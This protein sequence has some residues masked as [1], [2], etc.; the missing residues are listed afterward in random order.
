VVRKVDRIG[1]EIIALRLGD[2]GSSAATERIRRALRSVDQRIV[3][4]A[5]QLAGQTGD[6]KFASDLVDT[7]ER[8]LAGGQG[9]DPL[10]RAK[11]AVLATLTELG[12]DDFDVY[13]RALKVRQFDPS[14]GVPPPGEETAGAVRSISALKLPMTGLNTEDLVRSLGPMLFDSSPHVRQNV[15][16]ALGACGS[17]EAF[18]LIEVKLTA[19]DDE[20]GVLGECFSELLNADIGR[21]LE[22]VADYLNDFNPEIRLQAICT[23]TECRNPMGVEALLASL[24]S[25]TDS[26]DL[27][28]IYQALGRSRHDIAINFLNDRLANGSKV[29]IDLSRHALAQREL[30]SV[31]LPG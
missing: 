20:P 21:Y 8:L 26:G 17:W 7:F 24:T 9:A 13:L 18:V 15:V 27:E 22:V 11:E 28:Q 6:T 1:E 12:H 2:D 10:C 25:F 29:E 4:A 16:R 14:S 30:L 31:V 3:V 19:G 23:L 5:A